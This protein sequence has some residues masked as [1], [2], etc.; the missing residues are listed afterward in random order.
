MKRPPIEILMATQKRSSLDFLHAVFPG[1]IPD[2]VS[3]LVIHQQASVELAST[4]PRVRIINT[5]EKGLSRSRNLA[6]KHARGKLCLITDDDV[7]FQAG[8][9]QHIHRGFEHFPDSVLIQFCYETAPQQLAKTYRQ[10]P[11]RDLSWTELMNVSSIEIAI[12]LDRITA[13][14]VEFDEHFG[15]GSACFTMGEEQVFLAD[16]KRK[17][18]ELSF[19]PAVLTRHPQPSTAEKLSLYE[20]YYNA[21]ALFTAIF[22]KKAWRWVGLKMSYETKQGKLKLTQWKSAF[23]AAQ[24]GRKHYLELKHE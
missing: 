5:T 15:L 23:K 9:E 21:G 8:F 1:G 2:E 13:L 22:E 18:A 17:H 19:Y 7:V 20:R 11:K 6:L 16:L 4:H 24:A 14:D 10:T 3:V 12:R